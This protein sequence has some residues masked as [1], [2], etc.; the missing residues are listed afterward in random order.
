MVYLIEATFGHD[1]TSYGAFHNLED[2]R[3]ARDEIENTALF[4][5]VFVVEIPVYSLLEHWREQEYP[6]EAPSAS[7]EC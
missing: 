2:A 3:T 4:E 1:S 7:E 6:E 5:A